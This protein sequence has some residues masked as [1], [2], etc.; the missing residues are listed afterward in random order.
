[1]YKEALRY[2]EENGNLKV[3]SDYVV[4]I[5]DEVYLLNSWIRQQKSHLLNGAL[6]GK[7]KELMEGLVNLLDNRRK[8][9]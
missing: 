6:V 4:T 8:S 7:R 5:D 9:M 1:M 3:P 2:L